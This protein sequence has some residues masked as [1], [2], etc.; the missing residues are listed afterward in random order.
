[1]RRG[2]S[3]G[4]RE[5]SGGLRVAL[6]V[7]D[8][9]FPWDDER[10]CR[11]GELRRQCRDGEIDLVV[12]PEA[13]EWDA[14]E[15][16]IEP[17]VEDL[18]VAVLMG[19][20]TAE[21]FELAVYLNPHPAPGDT[22]AHCYVKHS[23]AERLAFEWPAYAG[24][25]D[26][27]YDPVRLKSERIGLLICHDMFYGLTAHRE[28]ARGASM[29]VDISG[30]N[31]NESKWRNVV[32]GRSLELS[33][34]FLCTMAHREGAA[35]KALALAYHGLRAYLPVVR[36]TRESGGGGFTLFDVASEQLG[37]VEDGQ[38]AHTD[39]VYAD[40]T[41]ALGTGA[42]AD[43]QIEINGDVACISSRRAGRSR[44]NWHEVT[45]LAGRT[46]ALLLP[47]DAMRDGS[48]LHQE[49]PVEG[50]FDHHIVVYA[51]T[52]ARET[53]EELLALAKLHAIE[54]RIGVA[55][56]AGQTREV[57]KTNRYKNIQR[58]R[59]RQGRFGLNAEF[60]GG[61]WSTATAGSRLGIPRECFTTYLRL[62]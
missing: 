61:L 9:R 17:W 14:T 32:R 18:G 5:P 15:S 7:P 8:G 48:R 54:H 16:D 6:V 19:V 59:E 22:A 3:A 50:A 55:V 49:Q 47:L 1:M 51:G 52:R 56:L 33:A 46:G 23:T 25:A 12:F 24:P 40:I 30:G 57:L 37:D 20:H 43:V 28:R 26:R 13:Y 31:V 58:F 29:Y 10:H 42:D 11:L 38:Q 21:G 34:P 39:K 27:M 53:P 45:G 4:S 60:L 44:G 35:G 2:G 62:G 36:N 41:V